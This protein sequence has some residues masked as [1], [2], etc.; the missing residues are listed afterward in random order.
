MAGSRGSCMFSGLNKLQ[1]SFLEWLYH[2]IVPRAVYE[3]CSLSA[4][5]P[6]FGAV[7]IFYFSH[8]AGCVVTAPYSFNLLFSNGQ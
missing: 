5:S 6:A 2:V 3:R 7:T 8:S 1:N 4:F